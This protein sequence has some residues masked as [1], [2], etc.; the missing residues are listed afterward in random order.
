MAK[1]QVDMIS[2]RV[3]PRFP[4]NLSPLYLLSGASQFSD[5][6]VWVFPDTATKDV[7]YGGREIPA[8]YVG[9]PKFRLIWGTLGGGVANVSW[10]LSYRV[11]DQDDAEL[12]DPATWE[13]LEI[14]L[15]AAQSGTAFYRRVTEIVP[16]TPA[17]FAAE[18]SLL[19]QLARDGTDADDTLADDAFVEALM[20]EY[21]DV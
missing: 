14:E 2:G 7:L 11:V 13:E 1:H 9:T 4:V 12:L 8:N 19:W 15:V 5:R 18:S 21:E 20:L 10:K 3:L 17:N 6:L 16:V